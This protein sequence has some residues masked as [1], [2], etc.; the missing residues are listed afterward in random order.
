[1]GAESTY[2]A[3]TKY[4]ANLNARISSF[5]IYE[6]IGE[7]SN[8]AGHTDSRTFCGGK[9]STNPACDIVKAL[10]TEIGVGAAYRHPDK[11]GDSETGK[12][13]TINVKR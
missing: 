4:G 8:V 6:V 11:D 7:T 3:P 2:R 10:A 9:K 12:C 1:M 13:T 5:V